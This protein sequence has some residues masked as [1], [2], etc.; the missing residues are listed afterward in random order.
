MIFSQKTPFSLLKRALG[1]IYFSH[2]PMTV[3]DLKMIT[4][5]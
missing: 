3:D 2:F 1:A 4:I 5:V